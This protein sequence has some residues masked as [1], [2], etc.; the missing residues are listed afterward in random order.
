MGRRSGLP[1]LLLWSLLCNS[2]ANPSFVTSPHRMDLFCSLRSDSEAFF[3][4]HSAKIV[5]AL[6]VPDRAAPWAS[7]RGSDLTKTLLC[8]SSANAPLVTSRS[9]IPRQSC[10]IHISPCCLRSH[11]SSPRGLRQLCAYCVFRPALHIRP[12]HAREIQRSRTYSYD[13]LCLG[14]FLAGHFRLLAQAEPVQQRSSVFFRP[15]PVS[16]PSAA[17]PTQHLN[18]PFNSARSPQLR[19]P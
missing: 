7:Q 16:H 18:V 12:V 5:C 1:L 3:D 15:R 19:E 8:D 17:R 14:S 9:H 6:V 2:P 11:P 10:Q 4:S 13:N